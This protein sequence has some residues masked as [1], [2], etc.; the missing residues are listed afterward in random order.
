MLALARA[1]LQH[2]IHLTPGARTLRIHPNGRCAH[3]LIRAC[4][5]TC[6]LAARYTP[7]P[8]CPHPAYSSQWQMRAR[9]DTCLLLHVLACSTSPAQIPVFAP[10]VSTPSAGARALCYVLALARACLQ[11]VFNLTL[12]ARTL[13]AHP[14]GRCA[15][16]QIRACSCTCSLPKASVGNLLVVLRRAVCNS[17]AAAAR[18][19]VC[20]CVRLIDASRVLTCMQNI[21]QLL[22]RCLP[23]DLHELNLEI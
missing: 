10:C 14:K 7:N 23:A 8:R 6:S 22:T 18:A 21:V 16:A 5:C 20:A 19:G 3:A 17:P 1:R 2:V 13:H 15:R 12:G 11:H 9:S 4:S